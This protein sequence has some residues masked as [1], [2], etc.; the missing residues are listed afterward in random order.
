MMVIITPLIAFFLL[1]QKTNIKHKNNPEKISAIKVGEDSREELCR[2][3]L[4]AI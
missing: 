3:S 2:Y 4:S 1:K